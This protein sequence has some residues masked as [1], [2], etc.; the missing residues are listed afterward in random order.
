MKQW[1]V[2]LGGAIGTSTPL[3]LLSASYPLV[4]KNNVMSEKYFIKIMKFKLLLC[5][6]AVERTY[7][8][9]YFLLTFTAIFVFFTMFQ[10]TCCLSFSGKITAAFPVIVTTYEIVMNDISFFMKFNF[11]SMIVDEGHRLKNH[12]CKLIRHLRAI[13]SANKV[14]LTGMAL[15]L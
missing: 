8:F 10:W 9:F 12:K 7:Y 2:L 15:F 14:L 11:K 6:C 3:T 13:N 1:S 4:A 5:N